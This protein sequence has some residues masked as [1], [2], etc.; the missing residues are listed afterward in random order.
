M[1]KVTSS[2]LTIADWSLYNTAGL[3]INGGD[4]GTNTREIQLPLNDLNNG[5]YLIRLELENGEQVT[6]KFVRLVK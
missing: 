6:K 4:S 2:H 3:E 1:I 5:M